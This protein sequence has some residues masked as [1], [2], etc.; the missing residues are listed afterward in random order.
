[1]N[2][3]PNPTSGVG[4]SRR[5]LLGATAAG[6]GVGSFAGISLAQVEKTVEKLK[7]EGWEA[8][9]TACCM[10]G[11]RCGLLAMKKKGAKPGPDSVRIFPNPSH[12]QRGYCGRGAQTLWLWNHPLR[13]RKPLKRKGERGS[14]EFEEISWD[15]ALNEIAA[16]LKEITEKYGEKS[17]MLT[18]HNFTGYQAWFAQPFGTPNVINHSATCNSAST[19]G[20]RMVFGPAYNGVGAVDP[21]YGNARYL[22][23]VGRTLNCAA[24]IFGHA[25]AARENGCKLVME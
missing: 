7:A 19:L 8:H 6:V 22:L 4:I 15:Q 21:D 17:V 1:M 13:I 14:G 3:K 5:T 24:G 12:P 25:A 16:K 23:L 2:Q 9:P 10:C 18:S 11:A 20:R